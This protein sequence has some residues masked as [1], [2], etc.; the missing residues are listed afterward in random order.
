M[1]T[2]TLPEAIVQD[3][4]ETSKG[5][6]VTLKTVEWTNEQSNGFNEMAEKF[7]LSIVERDEFAEQLET[8]LLMQT[9][10]SAIQKRKC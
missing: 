2:I 8:I 5:L 1:I 4:R 9:F 10:K 6:E 3:F 7:N